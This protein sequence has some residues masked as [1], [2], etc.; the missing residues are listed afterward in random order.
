MLTQPK[1]EKLFAGYNN[2]NNETVA[3]LMSFLFTSSSTA[4]IV[5]T[6][7]LKAAK[8]KAGSTSA[9]PVAYL[10][11][12][13]GT[14]AIPQMKLAVS[15]AP[16]GGAL[17]DGCLWLETNANDGLKIRINGVTKTVTLS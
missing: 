8:I 9:T 10:D 15:A 7:A 11:I 3:E 1:L 2:N 4:T 5:A 13:A 16:T 14:T 6:T 12:A 17:T